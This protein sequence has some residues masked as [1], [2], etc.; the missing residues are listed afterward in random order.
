MN[1]TWVCQCCG[2][3]AATR[4]ELGN[5]RQTWATEVY[6]DSIEF[7]TTTFD[8]PI[9]RI[10][11]KRAVKAHAVKRFWTI[12]YNKPKAHTGRRPNSN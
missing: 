10:I 11:T 3:Y 12:A 5:C 8:G 6:T 1:T 7:K 2:K 9:G 4:E